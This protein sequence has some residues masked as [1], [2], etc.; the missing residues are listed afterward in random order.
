M[1][2]RIYKTSETQRSKHREYYRAKIE[3]EGGW[4]KHK[5]KQRYGITEEDYQAMYKR[6]NGLCALCNNP[7]WPG[8]PL[9]VDH[10]HAT[11][12]V[13]ALLCFHCNNMLGLAKDNIETLQNAIEYLSSF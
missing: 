2:E 3:R 8:K 7:P 1:T 9:H 6:Q 10:D 13:R 4:R 12:K 11:G 5:L